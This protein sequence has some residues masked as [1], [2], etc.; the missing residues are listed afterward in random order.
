MGFVSTIAFV[1]LRQ[2]VIDSSEHKLLKS[3]KI[4]FF[5]YNDI[6]NDEAFFDLFEDGCPD[7]LKPTTKC[8]TEKIYPKLISRCPDGENCLRNI[9]NVL[10]YIV[11][12]T[13]IAYDGSIFGGLRYDGD[14][15]F[16]NSL[17][18]SSNH[19]EQ[20]YCLKIRNN[21]INKDNKRIV[22]DYLR[23]DGTTLKSINQK[24]ICCSADN[25][26]RAKEND[27]EVGENV[28]PLKM[29]KL[30]KLEGMEEGEF[31]EA[32]ED[33]AA[34]EKDYEEVGMDSG[35]G[36]GEGDIRDRDWT[37]KMKGKRYADN[38]RRAK[39]NDIEV[40]ENVV[41]LKMQKLSKLD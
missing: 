35:E 40:G 20:L 36:E 37:L 17:L 22:E 29:Q 11:A 33:L 24:F 6:I 1:F 25:K 18:H 4:K 12:M 32:R 31:S 3:K 13:G 30:S 23:T 9:Q 5:T 27:I 38:K 39:E 7:F 19:V 28:V 16:F 2:I 41:P 8:F 15:Q 26:R 34:L 10:F 21:E 14:I